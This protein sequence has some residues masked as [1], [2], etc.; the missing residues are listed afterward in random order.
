MRI[1]FDDSIRTYSLRD[2]ATS[3]MEIQKSLSSFAST[4]VGV[5]LRD[6]LFEFDARICKIASIRRITLGFIRLSKLLLII[7]LFISSKT[8]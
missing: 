2:K 4:D 5:A 1:S 6:G 3:N 7:W 8:I